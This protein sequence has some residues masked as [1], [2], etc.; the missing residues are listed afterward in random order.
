V[1]ASP[2]RPLRRPHAVHAR[3]GTRID[4]YHWLRDDSRSDPIVLGH[5]GAENAYTDAALAPVAALQA[6]LRAE[7]AGRIP[8]ADESVPMRHNGWWYQERDEPGAEHPR[9]LRRRDQPGAPWELLVDADARAAAARAAGHAHYELGALEVSHDNRLLAIAED[10]LGR[11]LCEIRFRDL[12]SGDWLPDVIANAEPNLAW[13]NDGCS[14][15]YVEKDPG[16]L[17][18][19]RVRRHRVGTP[20]A[21]DELVHEEHDESFFVGVAKS[22]SDRFLFIVSQGTLTSEWRYAD[23]A[24]PA[25]PFHVAVPREPGHEY[26]LEDRGGEFVIRSNWQAPDFR[27]AVVAMDRA[28]DRRAWRDLLPPRAGVAVTG[29]EVL[30]GW[31]AV[32]ERAAGRRRIRLLADDGRDERLLEPPDD[33]GTILLGDNPEPGARALRY[34]TSSLAVPT[35]TWEMPLPDGAPI[36]LKREPVPGGFDPLRYL[37]ELRWIAARDG[38]RVPVT[39]LRRRDLAERERPCPLYQC[40]Y[41][42]YGISEDPLFQREVLSLVDRGFAYAFAQVR[43]GQELGRAWYDA[44]RLL[45]KRRSIEDFVDVTRALVAAGVADPQRL[46][47][48]GASAGGT[49]VAA[50]ANDSPALYRG[51]VAHKPFVDVL[52]SMLDDS[53]PL[54]TNE[55]EEW[56]DPATSAEAYESIRSW[57]PYDGVRAA[58]YP[59]TYATT[60][61]WDASVQYWEPAKWVARLRE[62]STSGHPVLLRAQLDSGHLGLPGRFEHCGELA[63]EYAFVLWQAGAL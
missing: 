47:A 1:A 59:A 61:L 60:A 43:G 5:L 6:Q 29:F 15:L 55:Y 54:T 11:G 38:T 17:L 21:Y 30:A 25:L 27:L 32:A 36:L 12:A 52:T 8:D 42:A 16:T 33:A 41:G 51:L 4:P 49:L 57:S 56:G 13:A 34:L 63:E 35:C 53:L 23:A 48:S 50:A 3:F 44:G 14:L 62:S 45:N 58:P 26:E 37:A 7:I 2:P 24:D 22:R 46:F 31:L 40:G 20:A 28:A 18:G 39:L 19:N 10:T 9:H